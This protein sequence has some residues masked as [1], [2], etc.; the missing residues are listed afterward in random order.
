MR[1]RLLAG[2]I[3]LLSTAPLRAGADDAAAYFGVK[4]GVMAADSPA[5]RRRQTPG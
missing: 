4:A 1:W 3:A 2:V 5:W